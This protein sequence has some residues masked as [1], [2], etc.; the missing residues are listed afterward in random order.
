MLIDQIWCNFGHESNWVGGVLDYLITDHLLVFAYSILFNLFTEYMIKEAFEDIEGIRINGENMTYIR[1]AYD[2]VL[3]AESENKL[4][5][6][7]QS[8]NGKCR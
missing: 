8:F 3:V 6:L 2:T 5:L 7:L 4:Q 1:C